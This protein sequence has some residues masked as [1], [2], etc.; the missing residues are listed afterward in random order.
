MP[1]KKPTIEDLRASLEKELS[2]NS[3]LPVALRGPD[4]LE[5]L[6]GTGWKVQVKGE[7]CSDSWEISVVRVDDHHGQRSWGWF[8]GT[9]LL[10]SCDGGPCHWPIHGYIWDQQIKIAEE[11]ARRLNAGESIDK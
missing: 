9:K 3:T 7:R 11:V 4:K 6:E 2:S 5:I 10:I 1:F 8:S